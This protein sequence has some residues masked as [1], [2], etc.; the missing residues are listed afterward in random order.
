MHREMELFVMA[1]IRPLDVIK[2]CTYNGAKILQNEDEYGSLQKGLVADL[3]LV[4]GDP[5]EN[6]SDTRNIEHVIV[7]G[8]LLDRQK[9]L[10][11]WR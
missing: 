10:S 2:M 8:G 1:G 11:S 6:I 5:A 7:R 9:L 4:S 3:I